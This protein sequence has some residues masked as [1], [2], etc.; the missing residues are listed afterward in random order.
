MYKV[1]FETLEG[2]LAKAFGANSVL[3]ATLDARGKEARAAGNEFLKTEVENLVNGDLTLEPQVYFNAATK[4]I[5]TLYGLLDVTIE[6][7]EAVLSARI[8]RLQTNLYTILGGTGLVL[9]LVLYLFAG[10]LSSVLR[11]LRSIQAGAERLAQGDVSQ[12]VNSHSKD[13]LREVGGAVNSVA[14]TLQKFTK[15]QLDMARAQRRRPRQLRNARQEP[16]PH[17]PNGGEA[18]LARSIPTGIKAI[19]CA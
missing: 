18:L 19:P 11:S 2:D 9:L 4:A 5:D 16:E 14:Q 17:P 7:L 12:L 15:A 8:H 6:Q 10:M 3:A 13:G 1:D